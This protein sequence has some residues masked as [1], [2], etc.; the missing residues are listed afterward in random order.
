MGVAHRRWQA[1]ADRL[2]DEIMAAG[3]DE[4]AAGLADT[5]LSPDIL[6][7]QIHGIVQGALAADAAGAGPAPSPGRPGDQPKP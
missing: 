5:G 6:A 3:A 4:I 2:A 7:G 1:L